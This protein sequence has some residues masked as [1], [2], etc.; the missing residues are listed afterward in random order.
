[1][2]KCAVCEKTFNTAR[3]LRYRGTYVTK[4]SLHKQKANVKSIRVV[5]NGATRKM[6][7]CTRCMRSGK[8]TRAV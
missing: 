6:S 4:R 7:V 2:G 5:V 3:K 1:M 8:V